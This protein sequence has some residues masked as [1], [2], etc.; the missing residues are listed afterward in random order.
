MG[1]GRFRWLTVVS[2]CILAATAKA[3]ADD[4][5]T[6]FIGLINDHTIATF[7]SWELHG[8]WTLDLKGPSGISVG[9]R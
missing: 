1:F 5:P 3:L 4:Q 9:H 6:H 2:L 8:T 7:G